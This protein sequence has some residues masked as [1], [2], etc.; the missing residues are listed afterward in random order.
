M[1]C[2]HQWDPLVMAS[3]CPWSE[4]IFSPDV[5]R[6]INLVLDEG[7]FVA[8]MQEVGFQLKGPLL[9][10]SVSRADAAHSQSLAERD[11]F[12]AVAWMAAVGGKVLVGVSW[13][14]M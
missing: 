8:T 14:Y 11:G 3:P 9:K 1:V 5:R 13:F 10:I 12:F 6:S 2:D 7:G 4:S